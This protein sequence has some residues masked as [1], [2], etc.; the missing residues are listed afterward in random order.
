MRSHLKYS[1]SSRVIHG[2]VQASTSGGPRFE[3]HE[4]LFYNLA[5]IAMRIN[6]GHCCK[7]SNK[8]LG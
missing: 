8:E 5:F 4:G 3:S 1:F 7:L 2:F 6:S